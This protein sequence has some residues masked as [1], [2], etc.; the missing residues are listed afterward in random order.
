[1]CICIAEGGLHLKKGGGRERESWWEWRDRGKARERDREMLG[2]WDPVG[3][4]KRVVYRAL[5]DMRRDHGAC[6]C[7]V[8]WGCKRVRRKRACK[9]FIAL[10]NHF[11][12][13][14]IL[15]WQL[16][17]TV[18]ELRVVHFKMLCHEID[19]LRRLSLWICGRAKEWWWCENLLG[20]GEGWHDW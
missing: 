14:L 11:T 9:Y 7:D 10:L 18:Y 17:N 5:K 1:M 20:G 19:F 8:M 6:V 4:I 12:W 15:V 3:R 16:R 2:Q 13:Y